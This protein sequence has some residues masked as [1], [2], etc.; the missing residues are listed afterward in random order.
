LSVRQDREL[1]NDPPINVGVRLGLASR[2]CGP[3]GIKQERREEHAYGVAAH[4]DSLLLFFIF[5][6][7]GTHESA[8][9]QDRLEDSG[10]VYSNS[11]GLLRGGEAEP[12]VGQFL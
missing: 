2:P 1:I 10:A 3:G 5:N 7:R 4:N 9:L 11:L 6:K 8:A 12:P